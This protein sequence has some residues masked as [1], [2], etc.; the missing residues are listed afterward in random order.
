LFKKNKWIK[1]ILIIVVVILLII[2]TVALWFSSLIKHDNPGFV[3]NWSDLNS[4]VS[5]I[6]STDS[7]SLASSSS[8]T[9]SN[10]VGSEYIGTNNNTPLITI[11]Q[12]DPNVENILFIGIDGNNT[13]LANRSDTMI[14]ASFNK[15][16]KTIKLVSIMRDIYAY[17]PNLKKSTKINGSYSYGGPGMTVN[18]INYN[19][20][21]DIQK[22]IVV[23]FAN[24][25]KIIDACGG[26]D[27]T[28][29]AK[30]VSQISGLTTS[31]TFNLN[32]K[33]A[34]AYSRIREIDSDFNRV[35]RQRNVINSI[36]L[37][38]K[39]IDVIKKL[40]VAKE[41]LSDIRTNISNV[42]LLGDLFNFTNSVNSPLQQYTIPADNLYTSVSSPTFYFYIDFDKQLPAL[43][44]FIYG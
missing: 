1:I 40:A 17:F 10:K 22:Y 12:K 23:D 4:Q 42:E 29:K 31:G 36:F 20:K 24:F 16:S 18:I 34:L 37:K 21:L 41:C 8:A 39:S 28:V 38:F 33:Q 3:K 25:N 15:K 13:Y 14:V 27:I 19:F 6:P 30:E 43:D 5:S 9:S 26:V 7:S 44:K 32:G 11:A 2:T 35:Q